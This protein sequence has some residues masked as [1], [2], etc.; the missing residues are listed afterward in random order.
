M[1]VLI[2]IGVFAGYA[3]AAFAA[4]ALL[5]FAVFHLTLKYKDLKYRLHLFFYGEPPK[6][7]NAVHNELRRRMDVAE[8][9][10]D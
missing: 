9:Q 4:W 10:K 6:N 8:S 7:V 3:V 2:S 5:M 1:D